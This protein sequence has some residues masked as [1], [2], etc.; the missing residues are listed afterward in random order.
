MGVYR[1]NRVQVPRSGVF[2]L[3]L[4]V[5]ALA[6]PGISGA[7][8][9][10]APPRAE[11]RQLRDQEYAEAQLA[12]DAADRLRAAFETRY[13]WRPANLIKPSSEEARPDAEKVVA[14][15]ALV[16]DSYPN[17]AQAAR[18]GIRWSGFYQY[19]GRTAQALDKAQEVAILYEGTEYGPGAA[20]A[21]GLLYLQAAH[22]PA[23][24]REWFEKIPRP[25]ANAV[26]AESDY[27]DR[28]TLYLAAQQQIAR[29]DFILGRRDAARERF[30][31]L[32]ER[33]P[34]YRDALRRE[35]EMQAVTARD[36]VLRWL[37]ELIEQS[38]G[39]LTAAP[40]TPVPVSRTTEAPSPVGSP[41]PAPAAETAVVLADRS[42]TGGST[43]RADQSPAHSPR[44]LSDQGRAGRGRA[45]RPLL[46]GGIVFG[47]VGAVYVLRK[48]QKKGD[49]HA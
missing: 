48:R 27:D 29:C 6:V 26:V 5:A 19:L 14:A 43:E 36:P 31:R 33:Y 40:A 32:A 46:L 21:V 34:M 18:A 15:Y 47:T 28:E 24:A 8:D 4:G 37:D 16:V 42:A 13:P 17:T 2:R 30:D 1:N 7:E 9:S 44:G 22:S 38:L 25:N 11:L 39:D 3:V 10:P 45:G 41:R 35:Y 49:V 23:A 20:Y 12:A